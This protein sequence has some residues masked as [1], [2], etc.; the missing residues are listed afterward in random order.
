MFRILITEDLV[1]TFGPNSFRI[2]RGA[3]QSRTASTA[4]PSSYSKLSVAEIPGY[5]S[6]QCLVTLL[7]VSRLIP[8][9]EDHVCPINVRIDE[10]RDRWIVLM[11]R[12]ANLSIFLP[13]LRKQ[14]LSRDG[15]AAP[16]LNEGRETPRRKWELGFRC[17]LATAL[18]YTW[19]VYHRVLYC[20]RG[21]YTV[22][23][24][25]PFQFAAIRVHVAFQAQCKRFEL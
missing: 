4:R 9:F 14:S 12:L 22:C 3:C 1:K 11:V 16:Q 6:V 13:P 23:C 19:S 2:H 17:T 15:R 21:V 7:E 8:S 5:C 20:V 25:I 18:H 10:R 24:G